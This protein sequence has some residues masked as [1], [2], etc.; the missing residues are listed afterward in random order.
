M[1]LQLKNMSYFKEIDEKEEAA[2]PNR[3]RRM[4]LDD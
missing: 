1:N 3:R 4:G 2:N